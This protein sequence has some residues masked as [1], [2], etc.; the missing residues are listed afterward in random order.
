MKLTSVPDFIELIT[1]MGSLILIIMVNTMLYLRAKKILLVQHFFRVQVLIALWMLAKIFKIVSPTEDDRWLW[2]LVEYIGVIF[3]SVE[4]LAFTY[5]YKYQKSMKR[6]LH[7]ILVALSTINYVLLFTNNYHFLFFKEIIINETIKGPVFFIH[8]GYS[9]ILL[10]IGIVLLFTAQKTPKY[11]LRDIIVVSVGLTIPICINIAHVFKWERIPFDL[12]PITMNL[13]MMGFGIAA[14]RNNYFDIQMMTRYRILENLYEG[15]VILDKETRIMEYNIK[16]SELVKPYTRLIKYNK[17]DAIFDQFKDAIVEYNTIIDKYQKFQFSTSVEN[18]FEFEI[19]NQGK[20]K[21]YLMTLQKIFNSHGD[22]NGIIIKFIDISESRL[23]ALELEEKNTKL[24]HINNTLNNNI[25]VKKRLYIEQERN[26]VSKEVHDILGHSVTIVISLLE[27]IRQS[28]EKEPEF[29]KE[30]MVQT[31][32]ITRKGLS[33]LKNSLTKKKLS[34]ISV[35]TLV[36]DLERLIDEF[37]VSGVDVEFITNPY[38]IEIKPKHFDTIYRICQESMTNALRHGKATKITIAV[39]F[40]EYSVDI[41]IADNGI[42][43]SNFVKGNGLKGMEQRVYELDGFFSCG[44]PDGEGF[45]LHVTL[46]IVREMSNINE[47]K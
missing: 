29:A 13:L 5:V 32:E 47:V 20:S 18:S 40:N 37:S 4:F 44:S 27:M 24:I 11:Q 12:T 46:P 10:G 3:F 33:E 43:C 17:F 34:A 22:Y 39:R 45:N 25:S 19:V 15:V 8:M 16:M 36:E 23:L 1:Y 30:K 42:G 26:R 6:W 35:D 28:Y 2:M 21:F 41:I 31:M 9:Y 38:R 7:G 14:F